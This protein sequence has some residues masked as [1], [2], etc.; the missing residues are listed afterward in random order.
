MKKTFALLG[1]GWVLLISDIDVLAGASP[2]RQK[3]M[4]TLYQA[5]QNFTAGEAVEGKK[6][7]EAALVLDPDLA[8]AH[9]VRAEFA[10]QEQDWPTARKHFERGLS[11]LKEPDQP[12]SPSPEIKITQ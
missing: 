1:V 4:Q 2:N 6:G 9:I 12:L 8:Y 5:Y 10:V 11:L 7:V 3:A